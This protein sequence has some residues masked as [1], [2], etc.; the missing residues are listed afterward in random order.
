VLHV[1]S[2]DHSTLHRAITS[3]AAV[4]QVH[5]NQQD[6]QN[7]QQHPDCFLVYIKFCEFC[8]SSCAHQGA[9]QRSGRQ[10]ALLSARELALNKES[11]EFHRAGCLFVVE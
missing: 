8:G 7:N 1:N 5:N 4:L 10:V 9:A 2:C 3:I 6:Q 11:A